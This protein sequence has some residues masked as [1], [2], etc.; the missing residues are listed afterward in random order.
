MSEQYPTSYDMVKCSQC[1]AMNAA[2]L[3]YCRKCDSD[4]SKTAAFTVPLGAVMGAG[5]LILVLTLLIAASFF[6]KLE[7]VVAGALM[8]IALPMLLVGQ[9][10]FLFEA[11]QENVL[12]GLA[13]TENC[14]LITEN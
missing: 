4:L 12:W 9:L 3:S 8:L 13:C 2:M 1:G 11:F 10:R 7:P 6:F 14:T 5:G